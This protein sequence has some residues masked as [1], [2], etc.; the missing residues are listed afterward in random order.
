MGDRWI[1][2]SEC[3]LKLL[4]ALVMRRSGVQ[5]PEAAPSK[6]VRFIPTQ[7]SGLAVDGRGIAVG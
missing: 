1:C 2:E 3:W 6:N 5:I 4:I 7:S